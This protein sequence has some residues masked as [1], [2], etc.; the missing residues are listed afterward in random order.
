MMDKLRV[1]RI[2]ERYRI[3]KIFQRCL[4]R[5]GWGNLPEP[6]LSRLARRERICLLGRI[7]GLESFSEDSYVQQRAL[8]GSTQLSN[9]LNHHMVDFTRMRIDKVFYLTCC[10]SSWVISLLV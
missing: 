2:S 1:K 5:G 6:K 3:K 9:R 4:R 7:K 10:N 8:Y